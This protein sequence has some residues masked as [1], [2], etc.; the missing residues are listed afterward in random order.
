MNLERSVAI[1]VPNTEKINS[2]RYQILSR[3]TNECFSRPLNQSVV[4]PS[5]VRCLHLFRAVDN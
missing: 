1:S 4:K 3:D 2:E 5:E